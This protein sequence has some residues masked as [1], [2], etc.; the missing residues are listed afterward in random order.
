MA[1][2]AF[3][4]NYIFNINVLYII[5]FFVSLF[6]LRKYKLSPILIIILTGTVELLIY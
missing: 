6:L 5:V 2:A 1:P 3:I 4:A